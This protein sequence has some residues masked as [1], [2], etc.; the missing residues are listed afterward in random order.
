MSKKNE[1]VHFKLVDISID[2]FATFK[3]NYHEGD[4]DF[5][6]DFNV[7]VSVDDNQQIVGVFSKY[8][9][10]QKNSPVLVIECGCHFYLDDTYW[11]ENLT[12]NILT[13]DKALLTHLLVLTVGT[14]R[15]VLHAK[16]PNWLD[17]LLLPT[18]NVTDSIEGDLSFDLS[19]GDEEE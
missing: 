8:Q 7:R 18:L 14:S 1:N 15:G 3:E 4:Y 9:F 16:K 13:L 10:D 11:A 6:I 5:D 17:S 12:G 19:E 2:Q